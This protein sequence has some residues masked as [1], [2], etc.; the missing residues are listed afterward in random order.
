MKVNQLL[1][2]RP[3]RGASQTSLKLYL[4]N[5]LSFNKVLLSE[6]N[7]NSLVNKT[8][9][10]NL[11]KIWYSFRVGLKV[12]Y[13]VVWSVITENKIHE[14]HE[15]SKHKLHKHAIA[16]EWY[17]LPCN[18]NDWQPIFHRLSKRLKDSAQRNIGQIGQFLD[19]YV[20][21]K[22]WSSERRACVHF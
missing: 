18:N 16:Q 3:P 7:L 2:T 13:P 15:Y 19:C 22:Y 20:T 21:V 1:L 11:L 12:L 9:S 4:Q 5:L 6:W 8:N 17:M 14:L 10:S